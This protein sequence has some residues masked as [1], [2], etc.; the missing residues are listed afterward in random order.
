MPAGEDLFKLAPVT[1]D[2]LV[3]RLV[4]VTSILVPGTTCGF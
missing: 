3:A 4:V 2:N 1:T